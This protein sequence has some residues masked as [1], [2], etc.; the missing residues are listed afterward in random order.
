M[1]RC[2]ENVDPL[3]SH[4][5][6]L[7]EFSRQRMTHLMSALFAAVTGMSCQRMTYLISASFDAVGVRTLVGV[8]A[9]GDA[10]ESVRAVKVDYMNEDML[11]VSLAYSRVLF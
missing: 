3:H 4:F 6:S 1:Q 10:N 2:E 5:L 11:R 7:D 9:V 8:R